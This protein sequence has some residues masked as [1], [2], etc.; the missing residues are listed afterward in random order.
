MNFITDDTRNI[1][2]NA[3][4]KNIK[5]VTCPVCQDEKP[6]SEM[7]KSI[8]CTHKV[9]NECFKCARESGAPISKC[10][11]CRKNFSLIKDDDD[12]R[13]VRQNVRRRLNFFDIDDSEP[14][15]SPVMLPD[16]YESIRTTGYIS[17]SF[18]ELPESRRNIILEEQAREGRNIRIIQDIQYSLYIPL[19]FNE[20]IFLERNSSRKLQRAWRDYKQKKNITNRTLRDRD[21]LW[22]LELSQIEKEFLGIS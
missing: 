15:L 5:I 13:P 14:M 9:C 4:S 22:I 20:T 8:N 21:N 7:K 10:P 12:V 17:N 1:L 11:L 3:V 2:K 19:S 6:D 18:W 16:N